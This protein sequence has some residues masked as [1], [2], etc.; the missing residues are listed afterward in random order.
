MC[1]IIHSYFQIEVLEI[2]PYPIPYITVA[3]VFRNYIKF[4]E[5]RYFEVTKEE[6]ERLQLKNKDLLIV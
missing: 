4:S 1:R 2:I 5:I 3:N 6:L